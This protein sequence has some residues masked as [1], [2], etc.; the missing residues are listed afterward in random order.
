MTASDEP[1]EVPFASLHPDTLRAVVEE[2]VTRAATDYGERERSLDEKI[3]DVMRQLRSGEAQ[4]VFDPESNS[5]NLVP[6]V[7]SHRS[8]APKRSP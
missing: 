3:E 1:I 5:V 8:S 7:R 4:I 6:L 2:F